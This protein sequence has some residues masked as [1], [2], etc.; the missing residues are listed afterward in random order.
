MVFNGSEKEQA[1]TAILLISCAY[2]T[3]AS[4]INIILIHHMNMT[5]KLRF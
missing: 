4:M 1:F 3:I 5:G 2:G